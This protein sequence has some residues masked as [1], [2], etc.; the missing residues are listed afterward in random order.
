MCVQPPISASPIRDLVKEGFVKQ[1]NKELTTLLHSWLQQ[2]CLCHAHLPQWFSTFSCP[3]MVVKRQADWKPCCRDA[4]SFCGPF[5][6]AAF[7]DFLASHAVVGFG[8]P[9]SR[10]LSASFCVEPSS[11]ECRLSAAERKTSQV[12][13]AD[14]AQSFDTPRRTFVL[15][16]DGSCRCP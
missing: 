13:Q 1:K 5:P 4:I 7:Y 6:V 12:G 3:L 8:F 11:M 16:A 15:P 10:P 2:T 14:M 9:C